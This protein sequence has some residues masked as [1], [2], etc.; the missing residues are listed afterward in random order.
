MAEV[1]LP[2]GWS[3]R[4]VATCSDG[5]APSAIDLGPGEV[6]TCTFANYL[7]RGNI[8]VDKVT[9]PAG[10]PTSFEFDPSWGSN[11]LLADAGTPVDSGALLPG[12]LLGG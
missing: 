8:I 10:D 6:V 7:A 2:A 1:N 3:H 12:G 4:R 11:F 9:D 5:S